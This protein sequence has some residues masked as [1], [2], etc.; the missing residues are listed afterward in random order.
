MAKEEKIEAQGKILELLPNGDYRLQLT[1]MAGN[2]L[3]G[4]GMIIF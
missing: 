2:D 3:E 4:E 1:S